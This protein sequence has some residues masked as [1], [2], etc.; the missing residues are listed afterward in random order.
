MDDP[1]A[2]AA[3]GVPTSRWSSEPGKLIS[4]TIT[5]ASKRSRMTA[6]QVHNRFEG[7]EAFEE[8]NLAKFFEPI[9]KWSVQVNNPER[10]MEILSEAYRRTMSGRPGP[11]HVAIPYNFMNYEIERY[12]SPKAPRTPREINV[13]SLGIEEVLLNAK[14]PLIIVGGGLPFEDADDVLAISRLL[15]A[16]IVQSWLRKAVPDRDEYCIGMA[17]IGGSPAAQHAIENAD[18]VLVFGSRFSEQMTEHFRMKFNES[19]KLIHVDIDPGVIGRV[20]DVEIGIQADLR[21]AVPA[22]RNLVER[23][24][25]ENQAEKRSWRVDLQT[26]QKEYLAR[27]KNY[28][29][30][31]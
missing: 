6:T 28:E 18:E 12:P 26:R 19:A 3:E 29:R 23:N 2:F 22:I 15:D 21:T 10:T 20:F 25:M 13:S 4:C 9:T 24:N 30:D 14:R 31:N 17:G 16:P 27:V 11:V 8:I 1:F 5:D 7:Y